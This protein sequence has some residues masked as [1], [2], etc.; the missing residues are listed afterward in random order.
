MNS[1]HEEN[2]YNVLSGSIHCR[3][4]HRPAGR[5]RMAHAEPKLIR[6]DA[7]WRWR[8]WHERVGGT[9]RC[10][11]L[12]GTQRGV[13]REQHPTESRSFPTEPVA[14]S[15]YGAFPSDTASGGGLRRD[16]RR[17]TVNTTVGRCMETG[18]S[19][20]RIES[21]NQAK[22]GGDLRELAY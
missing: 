16:Q 17:T 1:W 6:V 5:L 20:R 8:H 10:A 15:E 19:C 9:G 2:T 13:R 7:L 21:E 18:G 11:V 14:R 22:Y 4:C 3:G 12:C